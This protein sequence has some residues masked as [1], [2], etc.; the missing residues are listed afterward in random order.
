MI[1]WEKVKISIS[2][3]FSFSVG[4]GD[5]IH[6]SRSRSGKYFFPS[7]TPFSQS[8]EKKGFISIA[9]HANSPNVDENKPTKN[10]TFSYENDILYKLHFSMDSPQYQ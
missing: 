8:V 4:K 10:I 7:S 3:N 6:V 9:L 5:D 2:L 1:R